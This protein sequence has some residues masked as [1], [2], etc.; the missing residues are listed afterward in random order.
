M[1][2]IRLHSKYELVK[3]LCADNFMSERSG[4]AILDLTKSALRFLDSRSC[5]QIDLVSMVAGK[6]YIGFKR[7]RVVTRPANSEWFIS[8]DAN[9][10]RFW[11]KWIDGSISPLEFNKL[12]YTVALAPCLAMELFD[13]QNKK[14]PAT[15]FECFVGHLFSK[16]I[17]INP[18]KRAKFTI[19][20]EEV[21]M[22]MDFLFS[23]GGG[24]KTIHLPVKMSTRERVVQ[25]WAHQRMLDAAFGDGAY[26]GV[27]VLFSE[28]KLDSRSL[29]V[30]EICV[31]GQWLAYQS[32]LSKMDRIYYFD[33]P[34]RYLDLTNK[35]PSNI[36]IK[37]L[38]E[39]ITEI[40]EVL[41]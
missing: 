20:S 15:Y 9:V 10:N 41:R 40:E 25:A 19:D 34:T 5:R 33:P 36:S 37:R 32:L 27:M 4:E 30:T 12:A 26:R 38:G 2:R 14:G 1:S 21:S 18:T 35:Y 17:G 6:E 29:R 24:T 31:P 23:L 22:T 16:A 3:D 7:G 8:D 13:R 39:Y 28:T 11:T